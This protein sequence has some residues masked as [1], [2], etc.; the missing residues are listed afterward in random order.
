MNQNVIGH[1][2][3]DVNYIVHCALAT[4]VKICGLMLPIQKRAILPGAR[5]SAYEA[6]HGE[7]VVVQS[8]TRRCIPVEG[9][10]LSFSCTATT[11]QMGFKTG[12]FRKS[13]VSGVKF[14]LINHLTCV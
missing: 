5:H 13:P 1:S 4:G 9:M 2:I 10:H 8:K 7:V 12:D 6:V 14:T 11:S 3:R